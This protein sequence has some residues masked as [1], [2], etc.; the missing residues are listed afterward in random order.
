MIKGIAG[1]AAGLAAGIVLASGAAYAMTQAPNVHVAQA[2]RVAP[3]ASP[4]AWRVGPASQPVTTGATLKDAPR[5]STN[6]RMASSQRR[7]TPYSRGYPSASWSS[8]GR[9]YPG[10][11]RSGTQGASTGSHNGSRSSG[12]GCW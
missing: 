3:A 6:D 4:A 12:G 8:G 5:R 9:G 11:W 1:V 2:A 10:S 7:S